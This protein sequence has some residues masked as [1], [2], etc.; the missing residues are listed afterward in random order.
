MR[1]VCTVEVGQP[2][3]YVQITIEIDIAVRRMI[4]TCMEVQKLFLREIW[5]GLWIAARLIAVC[6]IG[7]ERR[8]NTAAEQIIG[9]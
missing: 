4:I 3:L 9:G 1:K 6:C 2:L 8:H 7:I 5:D